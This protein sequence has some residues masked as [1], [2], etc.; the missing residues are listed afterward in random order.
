MSIESQQGTKWDAASNCLW[1]EINQGVSWSDAARFLSRA[2]DTEAP[3]SMSSRAIPG[4]D[5]GI[6]EFDSSWP[7]SVF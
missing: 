6:P 7:P 5:G 4:I 2:V 1:F 3:K